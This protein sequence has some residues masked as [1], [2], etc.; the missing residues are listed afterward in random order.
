MPTKAPSTLF[1]PD[2]AKAQIRPLIEKAS[3]L[4]SEVLHYGLALFTRCS[5]RP[6]GDKE[7]LVILLTYRHFLET[8]DA[9]NILV[10]ERSPSPAGLLLRAMFEALL[11]IEYVTQDKS[12]ARSRALAFLYQV[13]L[14]R[15]RF[16]LQQDP[17]TSEG[18]ELRSFISDD[19]YYN[20][21]KPI[22]VPDL[23]GRLKEIQE[24]LDTPDLTKIAAEYAET[25]K[26]RRGGRPTW[27]SLFGGPRTVRDLAKLLK[28]AA[29][30]EL[31]YKEWSERTHSVDVI[32]RSLIPAI[33][34]PTARGLRDATEL[35]STIDFAIT[36]AIDTARCLICYYRPAEEKAFSKWL[37]QQIMPQWKNLPKVV[38]KPAT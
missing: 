9:V 7:N 6:E 14:Q 30:Y 13:E 23:A 36:F 20:D 2:L 10:E 4:L 32:D 35:N 26:K 34:G 17:S 12:K 22:D 29:A 8:L 1:D 19:P 21:W 37:L 38:V 27:H 3:P 33:S 18:K 15:R 28:R 11:T 25:K 16:Y 5:Y 31:L 24:M